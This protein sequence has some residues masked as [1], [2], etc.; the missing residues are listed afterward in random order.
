MAR[1]T[2]E[3]MAGVGQILSLEACFTEDVNIQIK[4]ASTK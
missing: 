2:Q 4:P 3:L 1:A